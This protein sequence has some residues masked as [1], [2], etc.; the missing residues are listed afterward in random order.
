[1]IE[2]Y[3][4]ENGVVV[5]EQSEIGIVFKGKHFPTVKGAVDYIE[6]KLTA[7]IEEYRKK[8]FGEKK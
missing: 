5:Q 2:I 7:E 3:T 6:D 4:L 8:M 1:M